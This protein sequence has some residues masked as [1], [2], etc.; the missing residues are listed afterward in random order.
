[1]ADRKDNQGLVAAVLIAALIIGGSNVFVG[2]RLN[3]DGAGV[4]VFNDADLLA[5]IDQGI[6]SYVERQQS[7]QKN[8]QEEVQKNV[9]DAA[10]NVKKPDD[11]EHIRGQKNAKISLIEYSDYQCPFCKIFH[12]TAQK[13]IENYKGQ[14]NW[15][16]RHYPLNFHEPMASRLA[17]ASEC[18]AEQKGND[19]FWKFTDAVYGNEEGVTAENID[20][21]IQKWA[22]AGGVKSETFKTCL[23]SEKFD[24]K[25]KQDVAEGSASGIT[26]TPGNILY[27]S[28][29]GQIKLLPGAYPFEEFQRVIDDMLSE[30]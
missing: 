30:K 21:L 8:A 15:V 24:A 1:M 18:V 26:G 25:I 23:A 9:E 5:K 13:V 6:E 7:E 27:N 3:G 28:E 12:P 19:G 4:E 29:T 2:F 20:S 10:Q 11:N 16:Y 22:V 17:V 14:V